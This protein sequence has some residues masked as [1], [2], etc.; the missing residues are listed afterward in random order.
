MA[1]TLGGNPRASELLLVRSLAASPATVFRGDVV[2][3]AAPTPGAPL[4]VRRVAA[5]EGDEMESST[6]GDVPFRVPEGRAWVTA[7]NEAEPSAVDS[8]AFGDLPLGAIKGRVVY[9]V[10][11]DEDHGAVV[12]GAAA[13]VPRKFFYI[14]FV[15]NPAHC[16]PLSFYR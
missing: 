9:A 15:D 7:D 13:L 8:R 16:F 12:R 11:A 5:L 6:E 2:L 1:P 10:R 4:L 14:F 3:L